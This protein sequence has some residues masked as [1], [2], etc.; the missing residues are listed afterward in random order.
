L[1]NLERYPA[2]ALSVQLAE[3]VLKEAR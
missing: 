1:T 3:L 2:R